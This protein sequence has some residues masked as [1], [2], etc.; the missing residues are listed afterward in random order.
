MG[1]GTSVMVSQAIADKR[2]L[3]SDKKKPITRYQVIS[4]EDD[5]SG[6]LDHP[7]NKISSNIIT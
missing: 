3:D 7:E 1:L 5:R 4:N 2:E 6:V